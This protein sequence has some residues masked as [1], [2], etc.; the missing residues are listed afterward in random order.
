MKITNSIGINPNYNQMQN[1][2]GA[3]QDSHLKAIQK[4]IEKV[5]QQLQDLSNNKEMSPKE[6]MNKRKE[7]QEKLQDLTRQM[8]QIKMEIRQEKQEKS[9]AKAKSQDLAQEN[10]GKKESSTIQTA[11]TLHGII[12]ADTSMRQMETGRSVKANM[13]GKAGVLE[14]EIKM[15]KGRGCSTEKKEAE[16]TALNT[17]IDTASADMMTQI[18]DINTILEKSRNEN[19]SKETRDS[20]TMQTEDKSNSTQSQASRNQVKG[21]YI[22]M[23]L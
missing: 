13:E 8:F 21:Q 14:S 11:T 5:Q 16:L 6:K 9:A 19:N 10:T 20:E 1:T 7:L 12:S 23:K 4:Q 17:R 15:D 22:D 18:S 3:N 2:N